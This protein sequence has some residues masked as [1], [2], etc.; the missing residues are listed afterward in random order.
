MFTS[1]AD[2]VIPGELLLTLVPSAADSMTASV[3][4]HPSGPVESG[5]RSLGVDDLDTVLARLGAHD[6]TRLALPAPTGG[7]AEAEAATRGLEVTEEQV[8]ARS[9]RVRVDV[10]TDIADAVATLEA[11]DSVESA[12]P[13]RYRETSVIPNDPSYGSEW[14]LAKI[15]APAAWDRTTGSATVVVGV[16]DTGIDLDHPDLVGNI[17]PGYDMVDLGTNPTPPAG[18]RFEGD[19]SGRDA[20]PEDEVGHG[21]HVAGTIAA[22][23]NNALGVAGVTWQC[24]I[25]PVKALTRMV[26]I[27]DGQVRGVG[28]SADIAAAVRYAADNG[29]SVINMSLGSSGTTTVESSAIAYAIGKG[30]VVVAAMGN[31]GTSNPSYPAAYPDVVSVGAID[32]ADHRASFSQTGPHIDVVAPGV[33]VL[34]TYLAAGYG[35]LSG[36]SMATPHVAGVAALIRSVKP[37]ATVA[38]VT[39]I[40]RTTARPLRDAPADPVPNDSYG[41]GCVDAAAAVNKASPIV[42]RLR[43]PVLPCRPPLTFPPFC[44]PLRTPIQICPPRTMICPVASPF[45]P[46]TIT[47]TTPVTPTPATTTVTPTIGQ[48]GVPGGG[49]AAGY[50][51]YGYLGGAGQAPQPEEGPSE[52]QGTYEQGYAD[53]YAAALA[54]VQQELGSAQ[55]EQ[56]AGTAGGGGNDDIVFQPGPFIKLRSPILQCIQV[57]PRSPFWWRCPQPVPS[58]FEPFCPPI[59]YPWT[60]TT[61]TTTGPTTPVQGGPGG[62]FEGGLGG[63]GGGYGGS[64]DPYGQSPFQG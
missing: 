27:S 57:T 23:S 59:P 64:Y 10:G 19:F 49:A 60:I 37:S 43:T 28:S 24:K 39:D 11:L 61:I 1:E 32:S 14:G 35:T 51:P 25:M 58:L 34:S 12:E 5:A 20:I 50:D 41:W 30:V 55:A 4:V 45:C 54:Q 13:N 9:F 44:G 42:T 62:G 7:A 26:R 21:S 47:P 16:I 2:T 17:V 33:G 15:N 36:T 31:D 8:L 48:P 18:F 22:M 3:P 40:L 56:M 52:G 63:Y 29:A 53:G 38:E 46:P 6:V